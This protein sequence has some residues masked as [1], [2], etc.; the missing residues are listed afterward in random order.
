MALGDQYL[1]NLNYIANE[2]T[3]EGNKLRADILQQVA[4]M[5]WK[6]NLHL[7]KTKL[8]VCFVVEKL[9]DATTQYLKK[10]KK[11]APRVCKEEVSKKR[12]D[13]DEGH[14]DQGPSHHEGDKHAEELKTTQETPEPTNPET[15][16]PE[17]CAPNEPNKQFVPM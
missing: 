9:G 16:Q 5:K 4:T 7:N 17:T 2:F 14:D 8:K 3:T 13:D 15:K 12:K 1:T 11:K 6:T 10:L